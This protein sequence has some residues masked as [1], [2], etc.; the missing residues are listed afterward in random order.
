MGLTGI[1]ITLAMIGVPELLVILAILV[2]IFGAKKLPQ[3]GDAMGQG[4][5]N[6]KAGMAKGE[7]EEEAELDI[8]PEKKAID[9]ES[10]SVVKDV[11]A[12][13]TSVTS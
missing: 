8:T 3:L 10:A 6:F 4:I 2:L 9:S 7:E 5:R 11:K 13:D 12:E 1:N